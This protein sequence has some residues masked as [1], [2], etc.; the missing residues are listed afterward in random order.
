MASL[1]LLQAVWG[2]I[3]EKRVINNQNDDVEEP[4]VVHNVI[5]VSGGVARLP[6]EIN[7]NNPDDRTKLVLWFQNNSLTPFYTFNAMNQQKRPTH[8]KDPEEALAARSIYSPSKPRSFLNINNSQLKD[9]GMYKCRVDYH[10]EQTSFQLVNLNVIVPPQKPTIYYRS[11]PAID[12]RI[13]VEANNS[14]LLV[15]ESKGGVPLPSLIWWQDNKLID[16]SFQMLKNRVVNKLELGQVSRI[17]LHSVFFC[18]A[19]NNNISDAVVSSVTLDI[20]FPPLSVRLLKTEHPL[21][22]GQ[23]RTLECE[24]TGARPSPKITW[25]KG[26]TQLREEDSRVSPDGDTTISSTQI[27]AKISDSGLPLTCRAETPGLKPTMED[28]WMLPV[29]YSPKTVIRLGGSLNS[30]NIREFDDVYFECRVRANPPYKRIEWKHNGLILRQDTTLGIIISGNSLAI[31]GIGRSYIGNYSCSATNDIGQGISKPV[32]LDIKYAPACAE[33]QRLVYEAAKQQSVKVSCLMDANPPNQVVFKWKFNTTA[34]TVDIPESDIKSLNDTSIATY[35]PRTELDFGTLVCYGFNSIGM[36]SPCI[37]HLLPTGPPD[38][39][40]HCTTSNVTYST[41]KVFCE[42]KYEKPWPDF[43]LEVRVAATGRS[44]LTIQNS[45]LEFEVSGLL[46]GSTYTIAVRAKNKFGTSEPFYFPLLTQLEPIK[47]IAETKLK[48]SAR[49]THTLVPVLLGAFATVTL[50]VAVTTLVGFTIRRR[51]M[52]RKPPGSGDSLLPDSSGPDPLSQTGQYSPSG[53][54]V[55]PSSPYTSYR[56]VSTISCDVFGQ[57]YGDIATLEQIQKNTLRKQKKCDKQGQ[58][59]Q[60]GAHSSFS[61]YQRSGPPGQYQ[62]GPDQLSPEEGSSFLPP[63]QN[64]TSS[65]TSD[66]SS[67]G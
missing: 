33:D 4:D 55:S 57:N 45:S 25:W 32:K 56:E 18:R 43:L 15:C 31:Q 64:P 6:C 28:V 63:E 17:H 37:Y 13:R 35:T 34:N 50:L 20:A 10:L 51:A 30:S 47:Q 16:Q 40:H 12:G 36:G 26:A 3:D 41:V 1:L 61:P 44:I 60:M 54:D 53:Q 14:A 11:L 9:A 22:E 7:R 2:D 66:Y 21:V 48:D 38:P 65:K 59:F 29:K 46:P 24:V 23:A 5:V 27:T 52:D 8:W 42:G 39:P 62:W 19:T 67:E 58:E 49:E